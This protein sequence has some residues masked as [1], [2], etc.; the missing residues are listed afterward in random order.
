MK[1]KNSS[2]LAGILILLI[3]TTVAV[4]QTESQQG[5]PPMPF[6]GEPPN[7]ADIGKNVVVGELK[8]IEK[9]KLTLTKP[10]GVEQAVAVDAN[11][12]FFGDH[13]DAIKL[14]DFK[15]GDK[16]AATGTLKDGVFVAAQLAKIPPAPEPPPLPPLPN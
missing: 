1:N 11:T 9:M 6:G 10:D 8:K 5:P 13:R 2:R 7:L 15:T 12:K 16:V 14:E 3:A 4:C